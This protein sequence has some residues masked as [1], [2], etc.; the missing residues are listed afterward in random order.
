MKRSLSFLTLLLT[1]S[2][3]SFAQSQKVYIKLTDPKGQL[4]V[5]ESTLKGYERWILAQTLNSGGKN[6]TQ[7][8]FIMSI[9]PASGSLKNALNSQEYLLNGQVSALM[10]N[11]LAAPGPSYTIAMEKIRVLDC[12][13]SMGCNGVMTTSV[14]L[15]AT[16]IGWT[17]YQTS[18][19][20]VQTVSNKTGWDADANAPWNGF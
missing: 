11:T 1:V 12:S 18:R 4:I 6:N 15:Q 17:Y 9:S 20:G 7:L 10:T 2:V 3:I 5:G 13:E 8:I 14:T 19:S 16:R